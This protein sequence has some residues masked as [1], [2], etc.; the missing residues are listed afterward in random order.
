MKK[1]NENPFNE[2]T[3]LIYQ[4]YEMLLKGTTVE[5]L[6]E[7]AHSKGG[8]GQRLLRIIRSGSWRGNSWEVEESGDGKIKVKTKRNG[9]EKQS[10]SGEVGSK[11]KRNDAV[12]P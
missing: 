11:V 5:Q 3:S 2:P 9:R 10:G 12:L 6:N 8:S 7:F 1:K 4:V